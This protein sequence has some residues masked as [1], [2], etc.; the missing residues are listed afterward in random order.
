[1]AAL[2]RSAPWS[3]LKILESD[4]LPALILPVHIALG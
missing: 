2:A 1:M 3:I 4:V